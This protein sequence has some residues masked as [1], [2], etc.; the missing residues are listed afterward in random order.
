LR[1]LILSLGNQL[2]RD[3]GVAHH[4]L[5]RLQPAANVQTR[6]LFQLTPEIAQEISDF[7]VIVFI[8]SDASAIDVSLEPLDSSTAPATT[9]THVSRPAEIVALSRALYCFI[10][11]AYLCR[12][13]VN[14]L[15]PGEGLSQRA[16]LYCEDALGQ[17][18][19]FSTQMLKTGQGDSRTIG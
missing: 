8:D 4:V 19:Q 15:S 5:N 9:L 2:R 13:P 6:A 10:G 7:D 14:D 12:I 11:K 16:A 1:I 18:Q 17:I 3:D